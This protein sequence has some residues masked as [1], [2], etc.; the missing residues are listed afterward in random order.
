MIIEW[1]FIPFLSW[2]ICVFSEFK[3][4]YTISPSI[5]MFI[6][7]FS[8]FLYLMNENIKRMYIKENYKITI[9]VYMIIRI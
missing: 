1:Y 9:I 6:L 5:C 4:N 2:F 3:I 7:L 8:I